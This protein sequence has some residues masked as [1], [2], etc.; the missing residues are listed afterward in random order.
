MGRSMGSAGRG[1]TRT[2]RWTRLVTAIVV[3]VGAA[4][5]AV[6][7]AGAL[8]AG[9]DA[10]IHACVQQPQGSLRVTTDPSRCR[11]S[12]EALSWHTGGVETLPDAGGPRVDA[13]ALTGDELRLQVTAPVLA[14]SVTLEAFAVTMWLD[15]P[16][17][18]RTLPLAVAA[19]DG[20]RTGIRVGLG[21]SVPPGAWLRVIMRGTGPKP[22]LGEDHVPLAGVVGGPPGTAAAGQDAVVFRPVAD[23]VS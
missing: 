14:G 18:W 20:A 10:L 9:E 11:P 4:T 5:G 19:V 12:E 23:L 16:G 22:V 17:Q 1:G 2:A 13:V 6:A 21:E 15:V 7:A 8:A 3:A